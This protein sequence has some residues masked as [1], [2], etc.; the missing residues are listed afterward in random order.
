MRER[1]LTGWTFQRV[2]FIVLGLVVV[3]QSI[4][5][6]QWLGL[7]LGSYFTAMGL[8]SFGCAAGNCSVKRNQ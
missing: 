8:F 2:M 4:I 3:V 1:I 5:Q 7:I 6:Q